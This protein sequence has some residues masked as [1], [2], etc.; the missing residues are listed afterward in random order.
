MARQQLQFTQD[1][2]VWKATFAAT[3]ETQTVWLDR[4]NASKTRR[5]LFINAV[6]DGN[7]ICIGQYGSDSRTDLHFTVR[8]EPGI[9]IQLVSQ[10]EID[11]AYLFVPD[12][13]EEQDDDQ[14]DDDQN[15]DDQNDDDQEPQS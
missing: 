6:M 9:Y 15:D 7:A 14:N 11:A 8:E 4:K 12:T 3:G 2:D 5:G 10:C 1:G 13:E